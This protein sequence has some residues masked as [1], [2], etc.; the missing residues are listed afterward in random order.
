[1]TISVRPF[2]ADDRSRWDVLWSAF[3]EFTDTVLTQEI[4]DT[5]WQRLLSPDEAPYGFAAV[6]GDGRIVGFV[7]YLFHRST[8][9]DVGCCYLEDLFV[10]AD[11][12]GSGAGRALVKAVETAARD[13]GCEEL[14]LYADDRN[15]TARVLYDKV[16]SKTPFI[17]YRKILM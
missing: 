12:R 8:W 15:M 17:E 4:T 14:Y 5:T 7:H 6:D 2:N 16:M 3:L 11:A 9:G 1:M 13:K 10:D